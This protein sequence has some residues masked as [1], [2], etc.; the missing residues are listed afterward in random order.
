MTPPSGRAKN[1]T[2][3]VAKEASRLPS[4]LSI[5]KNWTLKTSAAAVP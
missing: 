5:G 1:P 3:S 4:S 2:A